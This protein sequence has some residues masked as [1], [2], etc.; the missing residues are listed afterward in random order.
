MG[1]PGAVSCPVVLESCG[2]VWKLQNVIK[3]GMLEGHPA[4]KSNSHKKMCKHRILFSFESLLVLACNTQICILLVCSMQGFIFKSALR[5]C[6]LQMVNFTSS[7]L[8]HVF[9]IGIACKNL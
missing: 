8:Q 4:F 9:G 1:N 2:Q 3:A 5:V 6:I 7:P